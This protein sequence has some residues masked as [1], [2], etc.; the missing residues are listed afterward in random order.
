MILYSSFGRPGAEGSH[1]MERAWRLGGWGGWHWD[2]ILWDQ[3]VE[4]PSCPAGRY[5][6]NLLASFVHTFSGL[7][8]ERLVDVCSPVKKSVF[9][10]LKSRPL[11]IGQTHD[12]TNPN[13]ETLFIC[14]GTLSFNY[15]S[16]PVASMT[17][18]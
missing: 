5:S 13:I 7:K 8:E 6:E 16:H 14:L 18:Y 17:I 12:W 15:C 3:E 11:K 2:D 9:Q 4:G 1:Q 10:H